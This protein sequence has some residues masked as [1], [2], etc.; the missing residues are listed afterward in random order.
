[1]TEGNWGKA[2]SRDLGLLVLFRAP[3]VGLAFAAVI[4]NAARGVRA[5]RQ[6]QNQA[7]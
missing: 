3:F 2:T 1:M 5:R 4:G 6:A 7:P